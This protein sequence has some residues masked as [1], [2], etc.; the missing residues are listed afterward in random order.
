MLKKGDLVWIPQ[1]TILLVSHPNNPQAIRIVQK[2]EI[3]LFLREADQ[4]KDFYVVIADGREWVAN[5]KFIKRLRS[6][7]VS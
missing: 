3:G 4:D 6:D 2:P 1:E 5:K 7:Y